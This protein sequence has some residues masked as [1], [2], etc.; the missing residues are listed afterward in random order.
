[1]E[2]LY[3]SDA[4]S[5]SRAAGQEPHFSTSCLLHQRR[6]CLANV[7]IPASWPALCSSPSLARRRHSLW[8]ASVGLGK[9]HCSCCPFHGLCDSAGP[10][11]NHEAGVLHHKMGSCLMGW[12]WTFVPMTGGHLSSPPQSSDLAG[13]T[14]EADMR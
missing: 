4:G 5:G 12:A 14:Q 10:S 1:M 11:C 7:A 2:T 6:Q 8:A 9:K 3:L 13:I